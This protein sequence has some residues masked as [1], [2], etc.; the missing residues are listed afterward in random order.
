MNLPEEL[1]ISDIATAFQIMSER[2]RAMD[3]MTADEILDA[4]AD[5][6]EKE[7]WIQ[8]NLVS[9]EGR[10]AIGAIRRV[11]DMNGSLIQYMFGSPKNPIPLQ[12]TPTYVLQSFLGQAV[13]TWNDQKGRT[14]EE[15]VQ[16]L[17]DAATK[18]RMK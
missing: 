7:G 17:R 13:A 10:C 15:V 8:S 3:N 2:E 11:Q 1:A 14:K 18:Y 6:L 12:D 16:A 9:P 5:L 4:A